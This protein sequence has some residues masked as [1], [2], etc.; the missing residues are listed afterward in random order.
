MI[1]KKEPHPYIT[2]SDYQPTAEDRLARFRTQA[3]YHPELAYVVENLFA[4][5]FKDAR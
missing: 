5:R 4:K 3:P 1:T 2:K